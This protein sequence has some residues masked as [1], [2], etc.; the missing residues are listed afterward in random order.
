MQNVKNRPAFTFKVGAKVSTTNGNLMT[1]VRT[2]IVGKRILHYVFLLN[3]RYI[4]FKMNTF[5]IMTPM[6]LELG[7]RDFIGAINVLDLDFLKFQLQDV[8]RLRIRAA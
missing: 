6:N 4:S 2:E 5:P 3:G 1:F 8:K 7:R